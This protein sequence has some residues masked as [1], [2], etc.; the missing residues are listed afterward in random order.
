MSGTPTDPTPDPSPTPRA[1]LAVGA[2]IKS[3]QGGAKESASAAIG[4]RCGGL[5]LVLQHYT[6]MTTDHNSWVS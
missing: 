2:G 6:N 3:L 1:T 4:R 5:V